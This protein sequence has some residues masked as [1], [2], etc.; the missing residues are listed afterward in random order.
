MGILNKKVKHLAI[1]A[2]E[3]LVYITLFLSVIVGGSLDNFIR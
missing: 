1:E 2:F 3:I